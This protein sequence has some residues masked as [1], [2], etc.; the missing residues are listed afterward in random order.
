MLTPLSN[1]DSLRLRAF[2]EEATYTEP[3]V[4]QHLGA[5]E[6]PSRQLRNHPR[7]L[8]RTAAPTL[9]NVLLRWFWLAMPQSAS[10]VAAQ[11]P[12]GFLRVIQLTM[13]HQSFD[14]QQ[15][16]ADFVLY[17]RVDFIFTLT[18]ESITTQTETP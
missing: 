5:A 8:D 1:D 7:L 4:R 10:T 13:V 16:N 6:L 12:D 14:L 9:L 3:S 17:V 11:V 2:F 15:R 18:L